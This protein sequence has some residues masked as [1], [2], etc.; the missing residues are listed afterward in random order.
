MSLINRED[1]IAEYDR[2]HVGAPG[3]ARKLMVDAP[4]V[5]SER[6]KG[7]WIHGRELSREMIGDV[8]TAIF[9][10]GWECSECHC[11]VSEEREPLWKYCPSCGADMRG[12]QYE[13][14]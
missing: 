7:K 3:G 4:T 11:L 8:V 13:S 9:Y 6:K 10:E 1:L 14:D 12:E 2:V 5:E